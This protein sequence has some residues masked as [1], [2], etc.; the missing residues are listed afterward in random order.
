MT[1][2]KLLEDVRRHPA[3]IYRAPTDV[4]RDRRFGDAERLE[5][6]RAWRD[7]KDDPV[8][9]EIDAIIAELE[10]RVCIAGGHAAE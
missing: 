3:R 10:S 5:I 8:Q 7:A 9:G 6:L 2:K 4:L 1:K